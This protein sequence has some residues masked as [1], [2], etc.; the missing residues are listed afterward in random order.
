M[1]TSPGRYR[2]TGVSFSMMTYSPVGLNVGII[3]GPC[4]LETSNKVCLTVCT[5]PVM[6][7]REGNEKEMSEREQRA[8]M[9]SVGSQTLC[10][11]QKVEEPT[12]NLDAGRKL[13]KKEERYNKKRKYYLLYTANI[14][15]TITMPPSSTEAWNF[16][17]EFICTAGFGG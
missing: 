3:E 6:I 11:E 13:N 16:F 14:W 8:T 17:D 7:E 1:T 12:V 5:P 10:Q 15:Q 4:T 2:F 9:K